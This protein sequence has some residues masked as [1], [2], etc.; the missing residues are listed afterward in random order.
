[1]VADYILANYKAYLPSITKTLAASRSLLYI[2]FNGWQTPNGKLALTGVYIYYLN[3]EGHII[4]Y[5]LA[6][7][8]QLGQHSGINYAEVIGNVLN[9]FKIT[10][11]RL[12]YFITDNAHINNT[13]LDYLAVKFSFNK[14]Y[15][16]T[17]YACH[18]LNLVT[19]QLMFGK[20]KE[21]FKNKDVNIPEE[22]EFLEQWRKEG[23]LGTLYDLINLIN[24]P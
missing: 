16:C 20:N 12:G 2:S 4:D 5:M 17:H 24:T 3:K 23:L 8:A 6:L 11:E 19:Q 1:V 21:A 10:K 13:C 7:P 14:A 18:I 15:R 9:I 22:E